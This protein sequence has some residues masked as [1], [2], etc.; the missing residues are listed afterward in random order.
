MTV[1]LRADT[2]RALR[3]VTIYIGDV[4]AGGQP[5]LVKTLLGSCIAVCL[6]DPDTGVGGMN[7]FMLP[8]AVAKHAEESSRFGIHA[9]DLLIGAIMK[10]GGERRRL[11]AKVFGGGHVLGIAESEDSVPRQNIRFIREFMRLEGLTVEASDLGGHSARQVHFETHSGRA[12]VRRL[13]SAEA[14][15]RIVTEEQKVAAPRFGEVTLF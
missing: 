5:T 9:M 10:A 8:R 14:R 7:H 13:R 1:S 2:G 4:Y 15:A 11:R 12:R 6:W 3:E